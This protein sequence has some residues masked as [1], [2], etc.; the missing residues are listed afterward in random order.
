MSN[1]FCT[2]GGRS[3]C[4]ANCQTPA[5]PCCPCGDDFRRALELLCCPQLR[6]LIDFNAF[7]FVSGFYVLGAALDAPPAGTASGDNLSDLSGRYVCGSD[8]C[9]TITVSGTLNPPVAGS[10][11]LDA[12]VTQAALCRLTAVAFDAAADTT[13]S[14]AD[15]FQSVSQIL[16]QLLRPHRHQDCCSVA[17]ALTSAAAVRASTVAAGPL[18]VANSVILGQIGNI[19]VLAN[20]TDNRFYFICVAD[21]DFLG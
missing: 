2:N 9:E 15:N 5:R 10:T 11:A 14:A 16:G 4:E 13:E 12:T 21:I 7:A 19:L 18:V 3:P 17:D 1:F 8:S 6:S 20:S